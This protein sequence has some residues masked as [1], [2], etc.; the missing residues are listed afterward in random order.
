LL[1]FHPTWCF[2]LSPLFLPTEVKG[3][4][5]PCY[6]DDPNG[7]TKKLLGFLGSLV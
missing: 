3:G 6:L 4:S 1:L 2:E 5:H 7:F